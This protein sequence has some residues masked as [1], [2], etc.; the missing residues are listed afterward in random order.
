MSEKQPSSPT[1]HGE[2]RTGDSSGRTGNDSGVWR[3]L[4]DRD[5]LIDNVI[6]GRYRLVRLLAMGA[7]TR[8]YLGEQGGA[9]V[10]GRGQAPH[11]R[12]E[13]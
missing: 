5:P 2:S 4:H 9:A 3:S 12:P 7:V 11:P 13:R 1:S 8:I 10:Q 6:D